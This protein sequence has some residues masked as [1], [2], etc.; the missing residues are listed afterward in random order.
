MAV[1]KGTG[2]P[3]FLVES[4]NVLKAEGWDVSFER[5]SLDFD[6]STFSGVCVTPTGRGD[7]YNVDFMVDDGGTKRSLLK[8]VAQYLVINDAEGEAVGRTTT[9]HAVTLD[10]GSVVPADDA[11][12]ALVKRVF[13]DLAVALEPIAEGQPLRVPGFKVPC[14]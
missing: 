13:A 8:A 3:T 7:M 11:K 12:L 9:Q 10:D 14:C 5:K 1:R 2:W 6:C 4:I